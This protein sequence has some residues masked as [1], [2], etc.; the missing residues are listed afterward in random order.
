[1]ISNTTKILNN[2]L[3]LKKDPS[4]LHLFLM[5]GY[6]ELVLVM[7]LHYLLINIIKFH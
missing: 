3:E 5:D 2:S 1:M 4:I 6:K 7:E